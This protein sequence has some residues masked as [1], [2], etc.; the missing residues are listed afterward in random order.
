MKERIIQA[1]VAE[2]KMRGLKFSIRDVAKRAGISTKTLYQNIES[3]EQ[4]I[5]YIVEQSVSEMRHAEQL[6]I[7]ESSLSNMDKLHKTL[8]LLPS[9]LVLHNVHFLE[10][11][12][13]RYPVQ[14][15]EVD[16]YIHN[17]WDNI[18]LLVEKGV[19]NGELREFDFELFIQ[20]YIGAF[21]RLMEHQYEVQDG[22]SLERALGQMV[23]LL[24]VGICKGN[25]DHGGK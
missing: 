17:G 2:I 23:D 3:K 20:V 10:E 4:I 21:Y 7:N 1:S 11:L 9:R 13:Q 14:W 19:R 24:L 8:A 15:A 5:G 25:I 6:I 16:H 18:R 12:K 22:L